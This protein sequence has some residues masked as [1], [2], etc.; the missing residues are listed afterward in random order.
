[1]TTMRQRI[2]QEIDA[3]HK[4]EKE[5]KKVWEEN[6]KLKE[7]NRL[8]KQDKEILIRKLNNAW[9]RYVKLVDEYEEKL[10]N[11]QKAWIN[12]ENEMTCYNNCLSR[13]DELIMNR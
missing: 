9:E 10:K 12:F 3:R 1:M 11:I 4:A 6:L 2:D 13:V 8:L 5:K 7:E